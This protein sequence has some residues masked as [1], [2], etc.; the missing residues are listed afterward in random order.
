MFQTTFTIKLYEIFL[1]ILL[2]I[3]Q[4]KLANIWA[5]KLKNLNLLCS[6]VRD[7]AHDRCQSELC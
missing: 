7:S 4:G 3:K 6:K 1:F 5:M 2:K